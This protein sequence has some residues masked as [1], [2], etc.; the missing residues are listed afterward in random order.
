[1]DPLCNDLSGLLAMRL[2][3]D[4][5]LSKSQAFEVEWCDYASNQPVSFKLASDEHYNELLRYT[6]LRASELAFRDRLLQEIA[7]Q[8]DH[9]VRD[10]ETLS[11]ASAVPAGRKLAQMVFCIDVRS[12]RIRRHLESVSGDIET[13]G[14]AGFFGLPVEFVRLGEK[15]GDSQVPVLLKPQM[16]IFEDVKSAD[17]DLKSHIVQQ[18]GL[19]RAFQKLWKNLRTSAVGCF[20]FV[21]TTGLLYG[22]KLWKRSVGFTPEPSA[23]NHERLFSRNPDELEPNLNHLNQQGVTFLELTDLAESMLKNMGLTSNFSRIVVFC[24]HG[25]QTEN[26]PLKAGLD[27]GACGGHSGEPNARI[28]AKILNQAEV[29]RALKHRGI[30]IP[31]DTWF[32]AG[33]HNTTTD[34][35]DYF[36]LDRVPETHHADLNALI[37]LSQ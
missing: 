2:A 20:P 4:A 37:D 9:S 17:P 28:A 16:Q 13:L 5:A 3:Y 29:R 8:A 21:E 22:W 26:N 27:C 1:E 31:S 19:S 11:H 35:I 34:S 36:E 30:T 24:G 7:V 6:L 18:R 14:F 23:A 32:V 25:S 12:E 33:L 15:S 10:S